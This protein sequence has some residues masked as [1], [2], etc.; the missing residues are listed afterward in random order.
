MEMQAFHALQGAYIR[1]LRNPFYSPDEHSPAHGNAQR[2]AGS[3]QI[4]SKS[5]IREVD[6]IGRS[7]VSESVSR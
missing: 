4:T 7:W 6:Q 2:H 3:M 1:L 5:F